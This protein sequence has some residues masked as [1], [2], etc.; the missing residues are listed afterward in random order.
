MK[1][2]ITAEEVLL[3]K[4]VLYILS[5]ESEK[6]KNVGYMEGFYLYLKLSD[7]LKKSIAILEEKINKNEKEITDTE[8]FDFMSRHQDTCDLNIVYALE[9]GCRC[10]R[11]YNFHI[12]YGDEILSSG[13]TRRQAIDNLMKIHN[14]KY[15]NEK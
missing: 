12:M 5:S 8:R 15:K 13:P 14:E 4:D 7:T 3:L 2:D 10:G 9:I 11:C 1:N 6:L